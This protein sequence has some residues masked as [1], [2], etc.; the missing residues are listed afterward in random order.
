MISLGIALTLLLLFA[1]HRITFLDMK[2]GLRDATGYGSNIGWHWP[3]TPIIQV[4]FFG[5]LIATANAEERHTHE[6]ALGK[7]Y[8]TWT[9]PDAPD[10]SCCHDKDCSPAASRFVNN[11]WE[12]ERGGRWYP[13]PPN[14]IEQ[15]RD[16]PDGRSHLCG[17]PG[18]S[19]EFTVFCFAR[20]NGA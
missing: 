13:I 11:H 1:A 14:K 8:S 12:A 4:C 15:K 2:T 6:G 18:Y 5:A 10:V 3:W 19:G 17:R 20:G 16:S 9:M 7:F